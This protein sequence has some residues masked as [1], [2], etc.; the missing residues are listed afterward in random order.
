VSLDR[1]AAERAWLEGCSGAACGC[2][3]ADQLPAGQ[4]GPDTLIEAALIAQ[5]VILRP[6]GGYGLADCLR[7]TFGTRDENQR[8]L[9]A[10]DKVLA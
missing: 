2:S 8:L 5:G 6:M 3:V 9:D 10:L 1:N 7:I 4:F